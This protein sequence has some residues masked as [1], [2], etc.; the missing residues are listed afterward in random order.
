[1][2]D[3]LQN[4]A[5]GTYLVENDI[6]KS[7]FGWSPRNVAP[8]LVWLE[9]TAA[10]IT[11]GMP[12]IRGITVGISRTCAKAAG[13]SILVYGIAELDKKQIS[14]CTDTYATG[15]LIPV[16]PIYGNE[17]V[18]LR[19]LPITDPNADIEPD[20]GFQ[21]GAGLWVV[22]DATGA[23]YIRSERFV[24]DADDPS[25]LVAYIAPSLDVAA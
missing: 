10:D 9:T 16:I 17:G 8:R 2:V 23:I 12:L 19:N 24:A 14:V 4:A 20:V 21:S 15:D 3:L 1:M 11:P 25:F 13:T 7:V 5:K 18:V 22:G 6:T